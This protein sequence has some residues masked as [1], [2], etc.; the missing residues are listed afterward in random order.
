MR[1]A[2]LDE[3]ESRCGW[4]KTPCSR[5]ARRAAAAIGA[6]FS[7]HSRALPQLDV[8][9]ELTAHQ[10]LLSLLP[11]ATQEPPS[12]CSHGAVWARSSAQPDGSA[13]SGIP[14]SSHSAAQP[15][16]GWC[17]TAC[18]LPASALLAGSP[19]HLPAPP[20]LTPLA[21]PQLCR[22]PRGAWWPGQSSRGAARHL[23]RK[24]QTTWR[25]SSWCAMLIGLWLHCR[26][27]AGL[28]ALTDVLLAYRLR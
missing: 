10:H 17:Y 27:L 2:R 15:A 4:S 14:Q 26:V 25:Q 22:C 1:S 19:S 13:S 11:A 5:C 16:G 7:L 6:E 3:Q 20:Q 23:R 12:S 24:R 28:P 21:R 8:A 9:I 18:C